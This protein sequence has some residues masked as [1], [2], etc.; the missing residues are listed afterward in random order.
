MGTQDDRIQNDS[1]IDLAV[2]SHP[3]I[4]D[5]KPTD[6]PGDSSTTTSNEKKTS[7][8]SHAA[9]YAKVYHFFGFNRAYNFPLCTLSHIT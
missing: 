6:S 3:I 8:S 7:K 2:F 5:M 4:A 1:I 9:R